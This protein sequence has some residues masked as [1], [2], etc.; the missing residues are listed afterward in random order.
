[1]LG[2]LF[3]RAATLVFRAYWPKRTIK[4]GKFYIITARGHAHL[5]RVLD[6]S[7]QFGKDG[8]QLEVLDEK[9]KKMDEIWLPSDSISRFIKLYK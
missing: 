6:A 4:T 2:V 7:V 5:V 3:G 8:Y 1:M 9:F